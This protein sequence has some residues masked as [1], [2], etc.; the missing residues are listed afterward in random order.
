MAVDSRH[1]AACMIEHQA[2]LVL[3]G[4]LILQPCCDCVTASM[5]NEVVRRT[6]LAERLGIEARYSALT[7]KKAPAGRPGGLGWGFNKGHLR[8]GP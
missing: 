5:K 3:T 4:A 1:A 7:E 6:V 8:R 2:S